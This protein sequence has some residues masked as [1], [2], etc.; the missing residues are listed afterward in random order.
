MTALNAIVPLL[1]AQGDQQQALAAMETA[2]GADPLNPAVTVA[3]AGLMIQ[4]LVAELMAGLWAGKMLEDPRD[5]LTWDRLNLDEEGRQEL[6][7]EQEESWKRLEEIKGRAAN[8]V[9][10]SG[11]ETS[12]YVVSVIGFGR[13]LKAPEPS[14]SV[15]TD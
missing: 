5:W 9:A 15:K 8:R 1:R 2:H 12:P 13:A 14:H 6:F 3:L 11:E 10:E 7:E 4:S